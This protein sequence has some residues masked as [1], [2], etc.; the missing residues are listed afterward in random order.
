VAEI[1]AEGTVHMVHDLASHQQREL[2]GMHPK[3][4]V[5][6]AEDFFGSGRFDGGLPLGAPRRWPP[7]RPGP[8]QRSSVVSRPGP[9]PGA[10]GA[11]AIRRP[12]G[13]EML[14][15]GAPSGRSGAQLQVLRS[16][17]LRYLATGGLCRKKDGERRWIEPWPPRLSPTQSAPFY[18]S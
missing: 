10:G 4:K 12:V 3:V 14:A 2:E 7:G 18:R 8:G 16:S 6:P 9:A 15:R 5:P 13:R 11:Q 1:H 17:G